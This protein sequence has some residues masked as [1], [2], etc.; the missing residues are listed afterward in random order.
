[1]RHHIPSTRALLVFDAVARHHGVSKA[2][3]ELCITHSAV[4]QQLR[5]LEGQL[6]LQLVQRGARG[7]TLTDVGRRYHA[8][9]VGDLLRLQNHTLEAMAQR[10]DGARLLVGCVPVFA[11]RWLL[12]RLPTFLAAHKACSLHLQVYPTHTYMQEVPFDVA[13]QYSDAAWPGAQP[14]PLMS[15]VCVAVCAPA[16]RHRRAMERKDFRAVPLLQ[17]SSRLGAWD[18]WFSRAGITRVPAHSLGGHRFD[19]FS[20][21]VEAVRADLGVGLVP[22]YFVERELQSGELVLAHPHHDSDAR[23]YSLFVAQD[24]REDA[25]VDAFVQ[26]LMAAVQDRG[27]T[28]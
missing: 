25:A 2:A 18:A 28:G 16:S 27:R 3:E 23:G 24:R 11:E 8:Q 21:L 14:V 6:G 15:E 10:P 19:L 4:S 5:L 22:R 7:S 17:L 26:W 1:M 20:M 9:I 12:P 13:V